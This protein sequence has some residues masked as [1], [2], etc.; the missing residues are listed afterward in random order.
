MS[1][2][3]KELSGSDSA[4]RTR[5][6]ARVFMNGRSQAVRI[7]QEFRFDTDRVGIRREGCN[8]I[9]SPV[10]EDWDDYFENA[11]RVDED[12][13][14]AMSAARRDLMPPEDRKALD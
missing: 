14:M 6:L 5:K 3:S 12:F 10:Y 7:P 2:S 1:S 8:V 4:T 13:A 11:P 9:L